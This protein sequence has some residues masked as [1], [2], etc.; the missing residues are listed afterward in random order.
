[1]TPEI[2]ETNN[3]KEGHSSRRFQYGKKEAWAK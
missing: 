3:S 2:R 1:M